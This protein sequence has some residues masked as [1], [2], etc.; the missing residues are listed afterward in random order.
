MIGKVQQQIKE[1]EKQ[2]A[3]R[4]ELGR[5]AAARTTAATKNSAAEKKRIADAAAATKRDMAILKDLQNK[6]KSYQ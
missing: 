5:R 1:K 6:L 3:G 2:I 4:A